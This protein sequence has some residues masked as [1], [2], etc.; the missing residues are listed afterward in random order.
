MLEVDRGAFSIEPFLYV[1]D[2]L[3][4]WADGAPTQELEQGFLPIPSSVWRKDGITL[5]TTAFATGEAGKAVLYVR[6]PLQDLKTPRGRG[7]VFSAPR[8]VPASA[9]RRGPPP[10]A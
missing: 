2:K 8:P 9:P 1:D 4:T 5:R 10:R 6:Y 7:G 3:V